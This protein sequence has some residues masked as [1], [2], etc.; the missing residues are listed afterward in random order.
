MNFDQALDDAGALI[1][2]LGLLAVIPLIVVMAQNISNQNFD[3][4]AAFKVGI[5]GIIEAAKP[6]II[7]TVIIAISLWFIANRKGR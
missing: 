4:T 1:T 3:M 2:V 6:A 5:Y 7:P